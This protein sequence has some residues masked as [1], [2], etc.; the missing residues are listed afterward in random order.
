MTALR[1]VR[2]SAVRTFASLRLVALLQVLCWRACRKP[3]T[4]FLPLSGLQ[5][6]L[7]RHSKEASSG[8]ARHRAWP[9]RLG[10]SCAKRG[11]RSCACKLLRRLKPT[12]LAL[13]MQ[14]EAALA[15]L[16]T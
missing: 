7:C 14:A 6:C 10:M 15:P 8:P 16:A 12:V 5:C 2:M 1:F 3:S 4:S 11:Q 9:S 13:P